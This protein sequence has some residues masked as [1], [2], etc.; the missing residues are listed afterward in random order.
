MNQNYKKVCLSHF[1]SQ[2]RYI[3]WLSFM[4]LMCKMI[5]FLDVVFFFLKIL[6]FWVVRGVKGQKMAHNEKKFC[7]VSLCITG[8]KPQI[9]FW[10]TCLKWQYLEQF[11]F[12]LFQNWIFLVFKGVGGSLTVSIW[13][14]WWHE[15]M[16]AHASLA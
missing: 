16:P 6:I 1:I 2:E 5:I 10:C 8:T 15:H 11:F 3:I 14:M 13:C 9:C 7:L 4:V 12:S